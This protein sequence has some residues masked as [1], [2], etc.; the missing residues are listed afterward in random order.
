VSAADLAAVLLSVAGVAVLVLTAVVAASLL[1]TLRAV[2][3]TLAGLRRD[4]VPL[5]RAMSETVADAGAEVARVELLVERTE[6]ITATL[7]AS[8]RV[9]DRTVTGP[10]IKVTAF[11]RGIGR[12][13]ARSVV[14]GGR[15]RAARRRARSNR[16]LPPGRHVRE[17]GRGRAA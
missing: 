3:S 12:G 8:T 6:E 5:V 2:R 4:T 17:T 16:A 9:V 14:P 11:F 1:R 7:D 10:L 13:L 15:R